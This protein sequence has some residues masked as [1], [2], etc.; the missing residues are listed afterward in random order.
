MIHLPK[1]FKELL[2]LLN[3]KHIEY[4]VIGGYAVALYGYP[5]TTG[6]MDIWIAISANNARK[7]CEALNEFGF[8]LHELTER[9]FLEKDKNIRMGNPPLRI[10]MLTSIDGVEFIEC[11][12]NKEIVV[13]DGGPVNFISLNDLKKNK[14]ASGRHKDL[15]DLEHL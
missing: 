4:L 10:E 8:D 1:D 6:D 14:K 9:L 13:I 11:Y 7:V 2:R 3:S 5:R 15:D 12:K